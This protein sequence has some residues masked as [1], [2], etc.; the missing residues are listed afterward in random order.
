MSAAAEVVHVFVQRHQTRAF[1]AQRARAAE[2]GAVFQV[3]AVAAEAVEARSG[4]IELQVL[5]RGVQ[6]RGAASQPGVRHARR[7]LL[8]AARHFRPGPVE[9]QEKERVGGPQLEQAGG[10]R[11]R[12]R[13][14]RQVD[15]REP[16]RQP[17]LSVGGKPL[18][19]KRRAVGRQIQAA[20][21]HRTVALK[22]RLGGHQRVTG[23]AV[24][25]PATVQR[26]TDAVAVIAVAVGGLGSRLR[27]FQRDG[28][29]TQGAPVESR[30]DAGGQRTRL[31]SAA[32]LKQ[33]GA[34]RRLVRCLGTGNTRGSQAQQQ[35][36]QHGTHG[37]SLT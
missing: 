35:Q 18:P 20:A 3:H 30:R 34:G 17:L 19:P 29:R 12:Q 24:G 37:S 1:P 14:G 31:H 13:H 2:V 27:E 22:D 9:R 23:G 8:Q 4:Q 33:S 21:H 11:Q 28:L 5:Q 10:T 26:D 32:A 6:R 15:P 16:D 36:Q 25:G 7:R